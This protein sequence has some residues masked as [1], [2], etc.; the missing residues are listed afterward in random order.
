[1]RKQIKCVELLK[2]DFRLV[3]YEDDE[4]KLFCNGKEI[5]QKPLKELIEERGPILAED[6]EG[7]R[8]ELKDEQDIFEIALRNSHKVTIFSIEG[9]TDFGLR[10]KEQETYNV[11]ISSID[12]EFFYIESLS[13]AYYVDKNKYYHHMSLYRL[14][15][16]MNAM[17]NF[18]DRR[19]IQDIEDMQKYISTDTLLAVTGTYDIDLVDVIFGEEVEDSLAMY[20]MNIRLTKSDICIVVS[21][22]GETLRKIPI[23]EIPIKL[24]FK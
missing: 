4:L 18:A 2:G 15:E 22:T 9:E 1:M 3:T 10:T 6:I 12:R 5:E 20:G 19:E 13:Y 16:M 11:T 8:V 14:D 21:F 24:E 23:S 17:Q 7:D